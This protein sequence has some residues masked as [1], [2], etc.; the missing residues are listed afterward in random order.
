[1]VNSC[2]KGFLE[3][4]S[5]QSIIEYSLLLVLIAGTSVVVLTMLGF[6]ISRMFGMNDISFESYTKCAY[7][8]Y[9][10]KE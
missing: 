5:G 4:E 2:F 6:S 10:P 1:M 8:K 9:S 3:D 7:D